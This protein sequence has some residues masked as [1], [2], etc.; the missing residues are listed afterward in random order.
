MVW[1]LLPVDPLP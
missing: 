1:G